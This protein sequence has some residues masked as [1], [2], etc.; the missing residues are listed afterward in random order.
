[1][2][3]LVI[4]KSLKITILLI[5][6][7]VAVVLIG[8]A[9]RL[10][11][12][13]SVAPAN[14]VVEAGTDL[15]PLELVWQSL[16]QGGEEKDAFDAVIALVTAL[17][18]TYIRIDHLYDFYHVVA[19]NGDQLTFTWAELDK[20]VDQI[21]QM[22]AKPFITLSYM[23]PVIAKNG[24][25]TAE[26]EN[27]QDWQTVVQRTVAHFSGRQARNINGVIYE[28]WNEPDLF[29]GWT[30][31]PSASEGRDYRLLYHYA[32]KG[33]GQ[34]Q[35]TND[36]Q[37][38]GPGT[39]APYQDWTDSF[40]QYIREHQL[41][42]D[43]YSWHRYS[44]DPQTFGQDIDQVN[45]WLAA[46]GKA[47]LPKYLTEWGSDPKNNPNH[48]NQVD[49][50]HL[51]ATASQLA[52][53][54]DLAMI[55]EIKDGPDPAG[56]QFWGRW[57]LLTHEATDEQVIKKPKYQALQLLSKITGRRLVLTGG[58]DFVT[59]LASKSAAG[60]TVRL[61]L[62]NYDHQGKRFETVPITVKG[63]ANGTYVA[64]ITWLDQ[65]EEASLFIVNDGTFHQEF[66]FSPNSIL[67][68]ELF[69]TIN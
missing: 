41:R 36:F 55:F 9:T 24:D 21:L 3:K 56:K 38:G 22:G 66:P 63:L 43:F 27:W 16:A 20:V 1:M 48:D 40:L 69:K 11:P 6:L 46:N 65:P 33:A 53:R 31:K 12:L 61:I 59:G 67:L 13:A 49:A 18:P 14:I 54:V 15:G 26:P 62:T 19:K 35:N 60:Q 64:K 44:L 30:I 2:I 23:P 52:Q 17:K 51:I 58:N 34:A 29:G 8:R 42:L 45:S 39:T 37:I 32:A 10:L 50:A 25:I 47:N 68:L 7:P 28:V 4:K 57:G 5:G